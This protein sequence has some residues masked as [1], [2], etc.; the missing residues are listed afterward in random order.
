M[1]VAR[2]AYAYL[3][4][5]ERT[6]NQRGFEDR[7]TQVR[8]YYTLA[9]QEASVQLYDAYATGRVHGQASHFQLG[10][11]TFV[12]APSGE[13]S[14]LDTRTPTELVPAASLSFSGTLRRVHR[15]DGFGAELVA[16]MNDPAGITATPPSAATPAAQASTS[17]AQ[18]WS[19]MPSPSMT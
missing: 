6:A 16:V 3:F 18:S 4:F 8:D 11:W 1:Q 14:P 9:V 10:R 5:T 13:A 7:Q 2:Q 17:A 15:R 12:L 19:E